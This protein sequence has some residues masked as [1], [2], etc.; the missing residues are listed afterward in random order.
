MVYELGTNAPRY[1]QK[2]MTIWMPAGF[3]GSNAW[4]SGLSSYPTSPH[5]HPFVFPTWVPQQFYI[6]RC[7]IAHQT[8]GQTEPNGEFSVIV[9]VGHRMF[10]S[11]MPPYYQGPAHDQIIGICTLK[12]MP[13]EPQ[14]RTEVWDPPVFFDQA[15]DG[16]WME[17]DINV[18][19]TFGFSLGFL[20][21]NSGPEP[22]IVP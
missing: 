14:V 8:S 19:D 3:V 13:N 15:V 20:V 2:V 17:Q 9:D 22:V 6:T 16:L 4:I 5:I 12:A 7:R 11:G 18:T 10:N 1:I 21:P